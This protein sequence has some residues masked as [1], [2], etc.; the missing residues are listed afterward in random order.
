[1]AW[2]PATIARGLTLAPARSAGVAASLALAA[3]LGTGAGRAG[4][5]QPAVQV[6]V[7][8][9]HH[10]GEPVGHASDNQYYVTPAAFEAQM[11]YLATS[12]FTSISLEQV[13]GAL[14]GAAP[15]PAQ[16]VVITFDDGNQD[17]YDLALPVLAKYHLT[18]TFLIATGWVGKPGRLTWDEIAA[19][20]QA[21]M[22]FGAHTVSHPYLPPLP[23]DDAAREISAS[24]ADLEAHLGQPVVVFA[25]PYG[26]ASPSITRLVQAAGFQLAL[27]TSPY[28]LEHSADDLFYLTRLGVYDWTTL[29]YFKAHLPAPAAQLNPVADLGVWMRAILLGVGFYP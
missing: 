12:G 28:R 26:H 1:M 14:Q 6:P 15:L 4:A 18:A 24:K 9:Y 23:L 10:I 11:A 2:V 25:Y 16:P 13:L 27:G 21:G 17:N 7:L 29:S 20:R 8:M 22:R 5:A 3:C 19:M